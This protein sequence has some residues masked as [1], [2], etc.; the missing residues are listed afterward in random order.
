MITVLDMIIYDITTRINCEPLHIVF[1]DNRDMMQKDVW[2]Y[3]YLY[4]CIMSL[5]CSCK[6]I[7]Y[8]KSFYVISYDCDF[9]NQNHLE[10]YIVTSQ[11]MLLV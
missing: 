8:I 3:T 2:Y 7:K 11:S 6:L 4:K 5:H 10:T 1:P 9:K